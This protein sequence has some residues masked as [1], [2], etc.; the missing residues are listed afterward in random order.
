MKN[1]KS[2]TIVICSSTSFYKQIFEIEKQLKD[3]RFKVVIPLN[4][5][6]M[7][8]ANNFNP[9]LYKTWHKNPCDYK[10]KA[11]L[12]RKHFNE[13]EKGDCILV[14]NYN[15]NGKYGYIGGAVLGEMNLAFYLKK[16]IYILNPIDTT[17]NFVEELYGMFPI[18]INGN[19]KKI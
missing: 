5:K 16:P 9:E 11:Y 4:A 10:R 15:K 6:K 12:T 13:I 1:K 14:T 2:K 8:Q 7:K 17:S 19:L 3:L 18:I